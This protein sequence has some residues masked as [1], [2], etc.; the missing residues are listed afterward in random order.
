MEIFSEIYGQYY[1]IMS[2]LLK[3][4]KLSLIEMSRIVHELGFGETDSY[5]KPD[6]EEDTWLLFNKNNYGEYEGRVNDIIAAVR[7]DRDKA[8]FSYTKQFDGA[9]IDA[10]NIKV[11]NK[12]NF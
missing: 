12:W 11:T 3:N 4:D 6:T 5:F 10:S 2:S 9:D 7:K 1:R 8:I